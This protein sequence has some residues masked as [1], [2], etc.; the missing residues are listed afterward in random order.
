MTGI[1]IP[2]LGSRDYFPL[3]FIA[4]IGLVLALHSCNSECCWFFT[5]SQLSV[6]G[7]PVIRSPIG[8][9]SMQPKSSLYGFIG[10]RPIVLFVWTMAI[11]VAFFFHLVGFIG[12]FLIGM[13]IDSLSP[14]HAIVAEEAFVLLRVVRSIVHSII[15]SSSEECF[16]QSSWSPCS[17]RYCHGLLLVLESTC[18][19]S[20]L[21]PFGMQPKA[22]SSSILL[23]QSTV[24][25]SC[26]RKIRRMDPIVGSSSLPNSSL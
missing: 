9:Q 26:R 10:M 7:T 24:G 11:P 1:N 8:L 23:E 13:P 4:R 3:G 18:S 17:L 2:C 5:A 14:R 20:L 21:K 25:I 12:A 22:S 16:M 19:R 15:S 6:V